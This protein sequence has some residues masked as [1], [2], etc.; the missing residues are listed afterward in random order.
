MQLVVLIEEIITEEE[1]A[2]EIIITI[3]ITIL[4]IKILKNRG[5]KNITGLD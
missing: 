1:G 3:I 4:I 2:V 5:E